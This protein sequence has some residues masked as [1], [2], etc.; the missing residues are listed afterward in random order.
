MRRGVKN[1]LDGFEIGET[2]LCDFFQVGERNAF[3][4]MIDMLHEAY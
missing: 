3:F 4:C 1:W 2:G